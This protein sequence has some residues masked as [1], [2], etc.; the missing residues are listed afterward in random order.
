M[1]NVAP[2]KCSDS[3]AGLSV[4]P[5]F[6]FPGT[7]LSGAVALAKKNSECHNTKQPCIRSAGLPAAQLAAV[8]QAAPRNT[9]RVIFA[10]N[11]AETS[12]TIEGVVYVVDTLHSRQSV[13][14]PFVDM[15]S[16]A[17]APISAAAAKQRAGRAGRVRPGHCFRICTEDDF[18]VLDAPAEHDISH[19]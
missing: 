9:R 7:W 15:E 10:T 12:L 14:D 2:R 11:L 4:L 16:Q 13:Y 17:V 19:L 8:F 3:I 18:K 6:W 5:I 1:Q